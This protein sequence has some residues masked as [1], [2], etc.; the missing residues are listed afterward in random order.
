[1][2]LI[3]LLT[4]LGG[5]GATCLL[6]SP[7]PEYQGK[8]LG[9]W[10]ARAESLWRCESDSTAS[11]VAQAQ[12]DDALRQIGTNALPALLT[13][14]QAKDSPL[15]QQV[16]SWSHAYPHCPIHPASAEVSHARAL[17]GF[18]ILG[19]TAGPAVPA[20]IELV[21]H[22]EDETAM[23]AARALA[24]IGVAATN[25]VPALVRNLSHQDIAVR[26]TATNALKRIDPLAAIN[27]GVRVG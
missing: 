23:L 2:V 1:M 11:G 19:P 21:L 9:S 22:G 18:K 4:I 16:V 5:V 25:A 12:I 10:L 7:E 6:R 17:L 13:M 24:R 20:L 27:A 14:L 26:S 8:S 15:K 3:A